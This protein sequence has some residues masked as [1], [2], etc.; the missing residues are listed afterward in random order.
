MIQ[1]QYKKSME[2]KRHGITAAYETTLKYLDWQE[3]GEILAYGCYHRSDIEKTDIR[4]KHM[5]LAGD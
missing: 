5:N 1:W 4:T 3:C 2:V